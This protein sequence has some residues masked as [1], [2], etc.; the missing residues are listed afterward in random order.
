MKDNDDDGS[1][2]L[3]RRRALA[4]LGT[5]GIASA[6]AG[7]GTSAYFSDTETFENNSLTAGELDLKVD[8]EEHY[9]DW[10][11][12]EDV[13]PDGDEPLDIRMVD[14]E[15]PDQ[16][17]RFPAGATDSTVG[18]NP[19]WVRYD[20]VPQFM[21]NT[22]ID[23]LPDENDDG[24][25]GYPIEQMQNN[26]QQA[27]DVLADVGD[28]DDGLNSELRTEEYRGEPLIRLEDVKPGDFGEVTFSIHLCGDPANPGYVWMRM[29]GGLTASENGVNEPEADDPDEDQVEG[30]GNPEQKDGGDA[31]DAT[32]ELADTI[33]TALWYDEDCD[34]LPDGERQLVDL[35][36]LAD[37]SQSV[38]GPKSDDSSE[39]GQIRRAANEFVRRLPDDGSVN[40]G[41][42][43]FSGDAEG[44]DG[45]VV[46]QVGLD[47]NNPGIDPFFDNNGNADVGQYLPEAGSGSTPT[48]AAIDLARQTLN[49]NARSGALKAILL[50][51]DDGPNYDS[52]DLGSGIV[53]YDLVNGPSFTYTPDSSN[54]PTGGDGFTTI[55]E[56][57]ETARVADLADDDD[58]LIITVAV[59]GTGDDV[60]VGSGAQ[61]LNPFLEN[62]IATTPT[63]AFDA[64][65]GS[66]GNIVTIA[67]EIGNRI[68]ALTG[69]GDAE[70]FIFRGTLRELETVLTANS[71]RG[72]PLD[73]DLATSFDEESLDE[74]NENRDCFVGGAT[75][76]FGFSWWH[77]ADHGNEV[78]TDS[79]GFDIGF[80]TEQCRH[81]DGSGQSDIPDA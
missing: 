30:A 67:G 48:P 63:E 71:G 58:I 33:Q 57:D 74:D 76:C 2:E 53:S 31:A 21:D 34:N 43:T 6:G 8:W 27:C 18:L 9:S 5:V 45:E 13:D 29:P 75:H 70:Q 15:V 26:N 68:S 14:P 77:P 23:A 11:D 80:Y 72:L 32:V 1:F 46:Q 54:T 47:P 60:D 42:F 81:N 36:A 16:F 10:S 49:A 4:A 39:M 65:V 19:L 56:Q 78:Q 22:S 28:D 24:I 64:T 79:V 37:V 59:G 62:R 7:V 52:G 3:S 66:Q 51:T 25:A 69:D 50:V 41:F 17:R 12:D 44:F 20:D 61:T 73:G 38:D 35:I 55:P 40:A